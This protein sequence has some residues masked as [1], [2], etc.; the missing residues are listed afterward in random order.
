[1]PEG[2]FRPDAIDIKNL[3]HEQPKPEV[4][5]P[6]RQITEQHWEEMLESNRDSWE[7]A[8]LQQAIVMAAALIQLRPNRREEVFIDQR[9]LTGL[10]DNL[11]KQSITSH[12]FEDVANIKSFGDL[13]PLEALL[14]MSFIRTIIRGNIQAFL[15]QE[16]FVTAIPTS[17]SLTIVAPEVGDEIAQV[18]VETLVGS[19]NGYAEELLRQ[20]ILDELQAAKHYTDY[21]GVVQEIAWIRVFSQDLFNSVAPT[22]EQWGELTRYYYRIVQTRNWR[23]AAVYARNLAI[24]GA[25]AIRLTDKGL[26]I[27]NEPEP[28]D[29]QNH[30]LP[31]QRKF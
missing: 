25:K 7:S 9:L 26:V 12:W 16:N 5:N 28:L 2:L 27:E 8:D 18:Y 17:A 14:S 4:G 24:V 29:T 30:S 6:E 15:R 19:G 1:M 23:Q 3:V 10:V 22:P 21:S 13:Q 11:G 20:H 31:E